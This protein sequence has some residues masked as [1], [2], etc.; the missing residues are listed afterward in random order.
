MYTNKNF[1]YNPLKMHFFSEEKKE[2]NITDSYIKNVK[3]NDFYDPI[4]LG[5][6]ITP[7]P[8]AVIVGN[9]YTKAYSKKDRAKA[10]KEIIKH[11]I[12]NLVKAPVKIPVVAIKTTANIPEATYKFGKDLVDK[13]K[14]PK[15][16]YKRFKKNVNNGIDSIE[17]WY[18]NKLR[19]KTRNK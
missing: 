8:G 17:S 2:N 1:M 16:T 9:A 10:Y 18:S 6:M 15:R 11:P 5:S 4:M 19:N 7:I 12:K 13:I 14:N 3:K